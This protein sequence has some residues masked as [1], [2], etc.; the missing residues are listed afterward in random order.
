MSTVSLAPS[1]LAAS[2]R[3][4]DTSRN[5]D[6]KSQMLAI[7]GGRFCDPKMNRGIAVQWSLHFKTTR[8]TI[9]IWSQIEGGLKMEGNLPGILKI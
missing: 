7:V 3:L 1:F 5:E 2:S 8:S 4:S 9:R 6:I